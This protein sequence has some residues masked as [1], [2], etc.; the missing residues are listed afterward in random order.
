MRDQAFSDVSSFF[1]PKRQ[2]GIAGDAAVQ[3]L[4]REVVK[5]LSRNAFTDPLGAADA[6]AE[7]ARYCAALL[8]T[9]T[10][11]ASALARDALAGGMSFD[12]LCE[13]RLAPAARR[14]GTLWEEDRL[15]FAEVAL[16]ANRLFA[17]LRSLAHRPTPR[18]D[19]RFAVFSVPP[20]EEHVLGVTMAAERARGAGW[21]VALI[22][23][24][25][26]DALVARIA[27]TGPD[28]IGLS[29]SSPRGLLPLTR[30]VV[31][32]R[33]AAPAAPIVVSGPGVAHLQEPLPGVDVMTPDYN[34]AMSAL[35]RLAG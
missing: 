5:R 33:V 22:L 6:A 14:L 35:S 30:L 17:V 19:T 31:A 2:E 15:S 29:L 27:D 23:G 25:P 8:G 3:S 1:L 32:L 12:A 21:D 10:D 4:A 34:V 7:V 28:V 20:G 11:E 16:A 18:A 24:L 13:L 9:D 26:H